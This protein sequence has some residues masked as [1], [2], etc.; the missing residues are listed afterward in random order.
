[1]QGD[2]TNMEPDFKADVVFCS[3]VLELFEEPW[4]LFERRENSKEYIIILAP[5]RETLE[6]EEHRF[7]FKDENIL[8]D[9]N[10]FGLVYADTIDA[11]GI[12]NSYYPGEQILLVY[13]KD[14]CRRLDCL[15]KGAVNSS[16][17]ECNA[18]LTR[19][20]NLLQEKLNKAND[21]LQQKMSEV[22]C[23]KNTLLLERM[24]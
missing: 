22:E 23:V 9:G 15:V 20:T 13:A 21:E 16:R 5:Y 2:I 1:M 24:K 12:E 3:G 14:K 7:V 10:D 6:I 4:K 8:V 18:E 17:R 19:E 11:F